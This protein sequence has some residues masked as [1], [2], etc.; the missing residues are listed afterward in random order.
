MIKEAAWP[1]ADE[2]LL[3]R[4]LLK[5]NLLLQSLALLKPAILGHVK[6]HLCC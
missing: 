3:Q 4:L 5:V 1:T 6:N 2:I